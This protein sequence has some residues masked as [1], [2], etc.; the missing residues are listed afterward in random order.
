MSNDT[1][2]REREKRE[3]RLRQLG[4]RP[5]EDSPRCFFC[6]TPLGPNCF[7]LLCVACDG[8]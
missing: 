4:L 5:V 2:K 1:N 7:D 6:Q 3:A 8:D